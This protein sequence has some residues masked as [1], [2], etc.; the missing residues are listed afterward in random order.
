MEIGGR[1]SAI[2]ER[3]AALAKVRLFAD[4]PETTLCRLAVTGD[5]VRR[6]MARCFP[7]HEASGRAGDL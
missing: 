6:A 5:L 3:A 4:L 7:Q 1:A 2:S